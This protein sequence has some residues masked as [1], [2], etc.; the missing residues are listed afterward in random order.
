[1]KRDILVILIWAMTAL[2]GNAGA[3]DISFEDISAAALKAGG[4]APAAPAPVAA[5]PGA[6]AAP[7][8]EREWLVLV[9]INGRNDLA[10]GGIIDVNEMEMVGST[11]KVAVTVELG[12]LNDR[13]NS[14]RF[15][16]QK[17]TTAGAA[18]KL[19]DI[20]SP[21][22]K[23][24]G[25]DMGSWKHFVDFARWSYRKYP[26][27]KVM[28][29]LWGHGSGRAEV[30]GA[31]NLGAELGVATDDLTKNFIRNRQLALALV[32][33]ERAIGRKISIYASDACLMQMAS[34]VYEIGNSAE[35][36]VGSEEIVP[37]DGF[38]YDAV[39]ARL[40][41]DPG[42]SPQALSSAMVDDFSAYYS[43]TPE[44]AV[45]SVVD[46]SALPGFVRLLNDWVRA[47]AVPAN[48]DK[49]LW[50]EQET[51]AFEHGY[52][53]HDT[54]GNARSKDLYDF[55]D[56]VGKKAG[57]ASEVRARGELLKNFI[58]S[59]LVTA[60]GSAQAES[61]YGR[62]KGIAAYFPKLIYDPSYDE[63]LFARDS[64]WDDFLKW[65]L[66]PSYRIR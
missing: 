58:S 14:S 27:K 31:D 20:V 56:Q 5:A 7:A 47:A 62:S 18:K 61:I 23:V 43:A 40:A 16:I 44:K 29:V 17:D 34:V 28:V 49:I 32:E 37:G 60:S 52:N 48:R 38:P 57:D 12:L 8:A 55:V 64:L 39:L 59:R 9:F 2:T 33:I 3:Q 15:Y 13:G 53:G 26:A 10:Q 6:I 19:G 65:K 30:G 42:M 45:L 41:A 51:L 1:M 50:A 24:P 22:V 21:A 66:D 25:S 11:D 46:P 54:V 35:L 63:T 36:I 4:A